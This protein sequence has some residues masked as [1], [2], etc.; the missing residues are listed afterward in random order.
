VADIVTEIAA[1]SQEESGQLGQLNKPIGD[2]DKVTQQN[3]ASAEESSPAASEV[4]GQPEELNG[5]ARSRSP[6]LAEAALA[7]EI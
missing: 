4:S 5:R 6:A 7:L 1:S 2:V 3:T